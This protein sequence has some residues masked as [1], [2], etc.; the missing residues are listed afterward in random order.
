MSQL[1][2][3]SLELLVALGRGMHEAGFP[4]AQLEAALGRVAARLGV[5]AQFFSTP[6]SLFCAFGEGAEQRT[7]LERVE[8]AGIDLARLDRLDELIERLVSGELAPEAGLAA[9]AAIR[10]QPAPYPA[11]LTHVSWA[12]ASASAA[13]FLGGGAREIGVAALIGLGTGL[14]ARLLER[15]EQAGRLFEPAAAALAAFVATAAAV[16]LPPLSVY[17]ATLAGI[18]Y[19]IP[20]F[21]LTVALT[22]LATRHLSA[23]TA[24]FAGALVVFLTMTFGTALG[25]RL[26]ETLIGSAPAVGPGLLPVW[27]EPL[28]LVASP[29]ALTVLFRAPASQAFSI[30]VVGFV[31]FQGGRIGSELLSPELGMF[32]GAL[33]IGLASRVYGRLTGRPE[34]LT[35]VPAILLLVPGSI[36]YRSFASLL[37]REVVLGVET[38][39]KMALVAISLVAGLLV[40]HVA[41]PLARRRS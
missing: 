1:T 17:I 34:T 8:P 35:L 24:R 40:A 25:G 23:G 13:V 11:A 15:R 36:G 4:T 14:L 31:G 3:I 28:A 12:V 37:E 29:L 30:V 27:V 5:P 7:H 33:A 39:F 18:I 19:L 20:G 38:A 41:L 32:L 2:P 21:T 22:E 16:L 10:H 9:L 26:A 6:T